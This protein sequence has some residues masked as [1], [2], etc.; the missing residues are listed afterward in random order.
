MMDFLYICN[1]F[2]CEKFNSLSFEAM[3][4][5]CQLL[6]CMMLACVS[7]CSVKSEH[8]DAF[9]HVMQLK[10]E[11]P[12]LALSVLDSMRM[13]NRHFSHHDEMV[14][15]LHRMD[16]E[17]KLDT[18]FHTTDEAQRLVDYFDNHGS[19]NEQVL[20]NY[21]LGRAYA[22]THEAPMA[23]HCYMDAMEKADTTRDDC[24][25][26]LLS[27][28]YIQAGEGLD[29]EFLPLD[30]LQYTYK[31]IDCAYKV[32]DTLMAIQFY[33]NVGEA[34]ESLHNRDSA[35]IVYEYMAERFSQLGHSDLAA[36][37][38][39][40]CARL[41]IEKGEYAKAASHIN[42]YEK[43]SG[44]IQ[45]DGEIESGREPYY[46]MKGKLYLEIGKLDSAELFYRYQLE[47]GH[48]FYNQKVGSE[49]LAHVYLKRQQMDSVAKYAFYS[50]IMCDSLLSSD[51]T[52]KVKQAK[53]LYDYNRNLSKAQ[54]EEKKAHVRMVWL[55]LFSILI[56]LILV[57]VSIYVYYVELRKKKNLARFKENLIQLSIMS[58]E[59][60][61]LRSHENEYQSLIHEK[62]EQLSHMENAIRAFKNNMNI[63]KMRIDG[64][65]LKSDVYARFSMLSNKG[66]KPTKEDW[67]CLME[68]MRSLLPE[69]CQ[70]LSANSHQMNEKELHTC[71][72]IRIYI[73][74]SSIANMLDV[75][76]AYISKIRMSMLQTLYGIK[77]KAADFDKRIQDMC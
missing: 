58:H 65:L 68:M 26:K 70:M 48:D 20:A 24:D 1:M 45:K 43:E 57:L 52:G 27:R 71:M 64:D 41:Y 35:I 2:R 12:D 6:V 33:G 9:E 18:V 59:I 53:D 29:Y 42:L 49:G 46:G 15:R 16:V 51:I 28:V 37:W 63:K 19:P 69:F 72:L 34:Y 25:F 60:S 44:F 56:L 30:R 66:C 39:G 4:R 50:E 74:P 54:Q 55:I 76:N 31:A 8:A 22:D 38:L 7:A 73:R 11:R 77:G 61:Q 17:N 67:D 62:Q 13:G 10:Y 14:W 75:S 5:W 3:R 23:L 47:K 40:Y 21:L 32:R 36:G